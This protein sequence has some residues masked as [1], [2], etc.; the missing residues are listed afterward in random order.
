MGSKQC[1]YKHKSDIFDEFHQQYLMAQ[2]A[3]LFPAGKR[4]HRTLNSDQT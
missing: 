2:G 1:E 3:K 4:G